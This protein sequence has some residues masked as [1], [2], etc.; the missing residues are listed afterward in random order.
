MKNSFRLEESLSAGFDQ[1]LCHSRKEES[2]TL[3]HAS[4]VSCMTA[5]I[6]GQEHTLREWNELFDAC[7]PNSVALTVSLRL[8][9]HDAFY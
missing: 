4:M 2:A 8:N 1:R 6:A 3:L 5:D 7:D 9:C